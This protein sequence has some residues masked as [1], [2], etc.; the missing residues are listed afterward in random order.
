MTANFMSSKIK[1]Q[2]TKIEKAFLMAALDN[3]SLLGLVAPERP[4][5]FRKIINYE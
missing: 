5:K 1:L 2:P 3:S 4:F